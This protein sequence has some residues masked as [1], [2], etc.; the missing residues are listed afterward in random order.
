MEDKAFAVKLEIFNPTIISRAAKERVAL[1]LPDGRKFISEVIARRDD[2]NFVIANHWNEEKSV[3]VPI[4]VLR[5]AYRKYL[6]SVCPVGEIATAD[7]SNA[8]VVQAA[9][10]GFGLRWC[11]VEPVKSAEPEPGILAGGTYLEK[12]DREA[13]RYE[14]VEGD[15]DLQ[16]IGAF[17]RQAF[18]DAKFNDAKSYDEHM[19]RKAARDEERRKDRVE[20]VKRVVDEFR[21]D[22]EEFRS[23]M[24]EIVNLDD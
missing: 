11:K 1:E 7:Y 13:K 22:L 16:G 8:F 24:E 4:T 23:D 12:L 3:W 19:D 6:I 15:R 5:V 10:N 9:A 20:S 17:I 2:A 14:S 21:S 18:Y